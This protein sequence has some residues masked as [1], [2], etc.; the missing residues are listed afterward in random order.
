MFMAASEK[1]LKHAGDALKF[2]SFFD[3]IHL[4]KMHMSE[5]VKNWS[6]PKL[7]M[8]A[9]NVH[10]EY[11]RNYKSGQFSLFHSW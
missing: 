3:E 2:F 4:L 10:A 1:I 7:S 8:H 6:Q 9:T 11:Q 5:L